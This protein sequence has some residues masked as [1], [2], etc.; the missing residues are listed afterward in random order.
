M[1][2]AKQLEKRAITQVQSHGT[3]IEECTPCHQKERSRTK[4]IAKFSEAEAACNA[5]KKMHETRLDPNSNDKNQVTLL[6]SI[7]LLVSSRILAAIRP[8]LDPLVDQTWQTDYV[9]IKSY[10][11]LGKQYAR[12]AF[13]VSL[14][15][16]LPRPSRPWRSSLPARRR[17]QKWPNHR[18]VLLQTF[19]KQ[20]S[21]RSRSRT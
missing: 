13:L 19:V 17:Q 6:V 21:E 8:Q 18:P 10:E 7:K 1:F 16:Q 5:V 2:T 3:L 9:Q 14:E 12:S 20:L 4:I 11:A 15:N